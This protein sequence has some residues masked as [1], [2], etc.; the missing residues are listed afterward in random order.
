MSNYDTAKMRKAF[1]VLTLPDTLQYDAGTFI[2]NVKATVDNHIEFLTDKP[3]GT[4]KPYYDR[5]QNIYKLVK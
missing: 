1:D 3:V 4:Y 2:A 5:L